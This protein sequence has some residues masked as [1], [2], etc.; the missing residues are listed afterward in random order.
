MGHANDGI[1][2]QVGLPQTAPHSGQ[3][4]R[5]RA[6]SAAVADADARAGAYSGPA[7]AHIVAANTPTRDRLLRLRNGEVGMQ[8]EE[9]AMGAVDREAAIAIV[10]LLLVA[11]DVRFV[12]I[13]LA[14]RTA[15]PAGAN[16]PC[17]W[18]NG[19]VGAQQI[20]LSSGDAE[21]RR[22]CVSVEQYAVRPPEQRPM[23]AVWTFLGLD[24]P[25]I[26]VTEADWSSKGF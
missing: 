10:V 8:T 17:R 20:S 5:S 13:Q 2:A 26:P 4:S 3:M 15:R 12:A 6:L 19:V 1:C 11:A 23:A 21:S 18:S 7:L 9:A 24:D 22:V 16:R 25:L 14:S